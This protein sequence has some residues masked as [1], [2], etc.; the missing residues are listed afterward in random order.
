LIK[1][2]KGKGKQ[3]QDKTTTRR[4]VIDDSD[5]ETEVISSDDVDKMDIDSDA[6][7]ERG[8]SKK[9]TKPEVCHVVVCLS[10]RLFVTSLSIAK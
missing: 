9:T 1:K 2:S 7:D 3:R 5:D 4:R 8:G 10:W 6:E